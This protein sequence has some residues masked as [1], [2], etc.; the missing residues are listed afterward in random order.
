MKQPNQRPRVWP[1]TNLGQIVVIAGGTA[2]ALAGLYFAL[3]LAASAE[4]L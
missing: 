3:L 4:G 1:A 2:L